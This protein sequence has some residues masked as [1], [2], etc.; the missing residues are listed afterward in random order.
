MNFH[1]VSTREQAQNL[2]P[3]PRLITEQERAEHRQQ[4]QRLLIAEED[5][6]RM[7]EWRR[8]HPKEAAAEN[9]YWVERTARHRAERQDMRVRKLLVVSQCRAVEA[10]LP[11]IF[12]SDDE[13]WEDAFLS[14][15]DGI[16]SDESV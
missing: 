15:S 9:A 16:Y 12:T 6:W 7:A 10:G 3:P 2:A 1:N 11:S 8:R 4:Q 5:E 14:T 13:C